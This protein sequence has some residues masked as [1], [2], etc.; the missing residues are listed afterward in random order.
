MGNSTRSNREKAMKEST[1]ATLLLCLGCF[2]L[3]D[4][5]H[6]DCAKVVQLNCKSYDRRYHGWY[7]KTGQT[8]RG[9]P[10]WKHHV[11]IRNNC[12]WMAAYNYGWV[13]SCRQVGS[14]SGLAWLENRTRCPYDAESRQVWREGGGNGKVY[15]MRAFDL[16][17]VASCLMA[18]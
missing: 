18:G 1:L 7:Y 12:I 5:V 2:L 14:S 10:V 17:Y 8:S 4:K 16:G 11:D 9:R 6:G 15:W 3:I 13:G